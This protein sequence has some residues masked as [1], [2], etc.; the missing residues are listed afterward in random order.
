MGALPYTMT[1]C[2]AAL[3]TPHLP[4][5]ARARK[6]LPYASACFSTDNAFNVRIQKRIAMRSDNCDYAAYLIS[7]CK[8]KNTCGSQELARARNLC[9]YHYWL[10]MQMRF[11]SAQRLLE[12]TQIQIQENAQQ[13]CAYHLCTCSRIRNARPNTGLPSLQAHSCARLAATKTRPH[14]GP[15]FWNNHSL[16]KYVFYRTP[17]KYYYIRI[18]NLATMNSINK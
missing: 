14:L 5:R 7:H 6:K 3:Q 15:R 13:L 1:N 18:R 10:T 2:T 9:I 16:R 4:L 8:N 12:C 17:K 11:A